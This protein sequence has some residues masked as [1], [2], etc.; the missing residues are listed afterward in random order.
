MNLKSNALLTK[1][2]VPVI[3]I[4]AVFLGIKGYRQ[5]NPKETVQP[6]ANPADYAIRDVNPE[7]LRALNIQGDT[8][9]DTVK[10]LLGETKNTRRDVNSVIEQNKQLLQQNKALQ[11]QRDD[12]DGRIAEALERQRNEMMNQF[13]SE[14]AN[15]TS[16]FEQQLGEQG[17]GAG[18]AT[19][20][21]N[22]TTIGEASDNTNKN[23]LPIGNSNQAFNDD[24]QMLWIS[25]SD[26][27][28][29]P[30]QNGKS[31]EVG[32]SKVFSALD[33]TIVG[34]AHSDFVN[35]GGGRTDTVQ[36]KPTIP[37]YTLPENATLIGSVA[38]TALIG[39]IPLD[40]KV[41]DPY[42]F[43]ILIGQNNLTANGIDLPDVQGA[44]ISGFATGDWTLSCVSGSVNSMTFVFSDGRTRTIS[45]KGEGKGSG[46]N[47]NGLGW[48]SDPNGIPCVAGE[49]KTN[50]PQFLA[51]QFLL[52]GA[53]AAAD[54]LAQGQTTTVVDGN[55]VIGAV[56]GNQGKFI[57]G[58]ALGGGLK[59]TTAWL[60]D[61]FGQTF[62]AIYVPPGHPI[63]VHL[64]QAIEIDYEPDGRK[65]K[66]AG[67]FR[68]LGMD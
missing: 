21:D 16:R 7:E 44:V 58:Q 54:G 14:M 42:P 64:N 29:N 49:R 15:L 45:K 62:D 33:N 3:F 20:S 8:A 66:Y 2:I 5:A 39:R 37:V 17:G 12:V 57:L 43:K 40:S 46:S 22:M 52:S 26:M 47:T 10:T 31:E 51:S 11:Q 60:R 41:T 55:S 27:Q 50:A 63:A 36:E 32:L 24:N 25:P 38:M 67:G 61:R 30:A 19:S 53:A 23:A 48:I 59:E 28:P 6:T 56:T 18:Y 65:V 68:K 34:K 1:V 35:R 13:E 9:E 4:I